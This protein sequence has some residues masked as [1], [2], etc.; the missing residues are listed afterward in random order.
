[1]HLSSGMGLYSAIELDWEKGRLYV[2][3]P[4]VLDPATGEPMRKVRPPDPR[5]EFTTHEEMAAVL[6]TLR[7]KYS[8]K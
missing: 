6:A 4:I 2:V 1:M 8:Q 7:E 5:Q 3:E